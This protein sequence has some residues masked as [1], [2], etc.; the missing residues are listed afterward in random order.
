MTSIKRLMLS[1]S[2]TTFTFSIYSPI[3]LKCYFIFLLSSQPPTALPF[4]Y[5]ALMFAFQAIVNMNAIRKEF[6]HLY[7]HDCICTPHLT[8]PDVHYVSNFIFFPLL[9]V[10][11]PA[12]TT[13]STPLLPLS[14]QSLNNLWCI[15]SCK[16]KTIPLL[17]WPT[18]I[19]VLSKKVFHP[20]WGYISL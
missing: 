6:L 8:V 18:I 9:K 12:T 20:T 10:I 13:P 4:P 14:Q 5:Y 1:H 2:H 16:T 17:V 19:S 15:G 3:L 11:S 7:Q